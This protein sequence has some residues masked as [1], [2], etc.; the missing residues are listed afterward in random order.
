MIPDFFLRLG[1]STAEISGYAIGLGYRT[2]WISI[3]FAISHHRWL[4]FTPYLTF[5]YSGNRKYQK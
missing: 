3:D 1:I 4:G 5:T 2:G